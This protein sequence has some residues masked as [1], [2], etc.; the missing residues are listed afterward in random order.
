M[1]KNF[2]IIAAIVLIA[3][4]TVAVFLLLR[5]RDS[6]K[7]DLILHLPFNEGKG[8]YVTDASGNLPQT[9]ISYGLNPAVYQSEDQDPQWRKDGIAGGCLLFD[10]GTTYITYNKNDAKIS[11]NA[12]TISVWVA[13]RMFE[14]DDPNAQEKGTDIPT[15]I[16]SQVNKE[17]NQGFI[18]GYQRHGALTFQVGTGDE[19]LS[20]WTNG[21][22]LKTYEWNHV[23]ATFDSDLGEMCLYLNGEKVSSR[24]VP[25]GSQIAHAKNRTLLVGRNGEGERYTAGFLR[26]TSGYMD[27]LKVYSC[28]L[29]SEEVAKSFNSAKISDIEFDEIWLQNL[30]TDD[31]TRP[32][33]HAAPLQFWM[34]EPHA[35]VYYNGMYHL[36][37]QQNMAGSYWKNI[38][39]GH[40]VSTDL[41]NWE[42]VKEAIV[43]TADSVVPDGVW[44]GGATTDVN[45]VPLLF[46][47][48]GNDSYGK[49]DGLISNQNVGLAYPADLSDP[50]LTEWVICDDLAI[51]Q[52]GGQGRRGEFRDSHIWKEGD[53]WCLALCTGSTNHAGGA[54]ILYTTDTLEL[55][56]DGTVKQNWVYRGPVYEMDTP[57]TKYG[58]TWELPVILPVSNDAGTI[59]KYMFVFSPAPADVADNKIYY[60]LGD[61][62]LNTGKFTPDA[63]FGQEPRLFDYGAN[64]FTGPSGFIDPVSGDVI[65]FSI[66]QDQRDASEQGASG[67]AHTC[68]IARKIRL[69]DDGSD[70]MIAPIDALTTLETKVLVEE[71]NLTLEEANDKLSSVTGDM[72]HIKLTADVSQAAEFGINMKQGGKW[73]CTSFRYTTADGIIHGTTE[74]R[75]KSCNVKNVSG[76]LPIEDGKLTMDIYIDRSLV[77]GFFNEY[78]A[79]SIRAYVEDPAS[80]GLSLFADGNVVIDSLY[81]AEMGSIFK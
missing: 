4:V 18:L 26:M 53:T 23:V 62:D 20:I 72:L 16:I 36:F 51:I 67:W 65:M 22:N 47:T 66:M 42:P 33:Y 28:A 2:L 79:I 63:D 39:W 5:G 15:G 50:D 21:D 38:N 19:W 8:T 81:V 58:R 68:G 31:Y 71:T 1:K 13:P 30:L 43:P 14:W 3:A 64:V 44:S 52:Q 78:K 12:L 56:A 70:L 40:W 29:T 75:G 32:Q 77:E 60:Y 74:N 11:G 35:P 41:V 27:E 57:I 55:L 76:A 17:E 46:F 37:F 9:E 61:F 24:S 6:H 80:Q 73:D 10:G 45:G 69:T 49:V 59:T 54:V 48:A 7:K 25:A 34:N